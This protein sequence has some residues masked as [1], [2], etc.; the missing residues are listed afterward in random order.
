MNTITPQVS[1]SQSFGMAV[2]FDRA[3]KKFFKEVFA[4]HP[5][6]GDEFIRRQA[7]NKTSHIRVKGKEVFVD[8]NAKPWRI[9][10]SIWSPSKERKPIEEMFFTRKGN[11]I[12]LTAYKTI[13]SESTEPYAEK[14]GMQGKKFAIAEEIANYQSYKNDN[15]A[16]SILERLSGLIKND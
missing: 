2:K 12:R 7:N 3:G 9:I 15:K 16:P 14:Y 1:N 6:I 13:L 8:I 10:G 4:E 11:G 5:E